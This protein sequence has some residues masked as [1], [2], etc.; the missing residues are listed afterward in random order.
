MFRDLLHFLRHFRR[1]VHH[2]RGVLLALLVLLALCAALFAL[3]EGMAPGVA[4]YLTLITA[5]TVGY[6]DIVPTTAPGRVASVVAALIGMIFIG[7]TV[8]IASRALAQFA[9]EQKER[10]DR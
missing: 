9:E 2:V 4:V 7:L 1:A 10:D 6:G 3:A 8:A 5:L